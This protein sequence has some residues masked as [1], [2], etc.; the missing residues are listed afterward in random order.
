MCWTEGSEFGVCGL[1]TSGLSP[2][3]KFQNFINR[4]KQ[5]YVRKNVMDLKFLI[6][7][8]KLL[9]CLIMFF[10]INPVLRNKEVM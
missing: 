7:S 8:N 4:K 6:L 1:H 5:N 2:K 10:P 3:N 9:C